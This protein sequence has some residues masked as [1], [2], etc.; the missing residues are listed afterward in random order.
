M[1]NQTYASRKPNPMLTSTNQMKLGVFALNI[2][3]GCT[4]TRAPERLKADDW[5]GNLK[6]AKA[7]DRA[8]FEA[9]LPVGRWRGFGGDSNP[10]GVS[11]ETYTW[12]AGLASVTDQ[13]GILT[14][15]HV[16]TVH[17]L[18]AAK[19]ATT[20]DHISGGRFGLNIICGWNSAEMKMFD[21]TMREHDERYDHA[22]EWIE[23]ARRAWTH[24]GEFDLK[25]KYF[26]I[27][28]G[29]SEPKP[30]NR[31]FLMNAG[32]SPRGKRFC[33]Q[34]CDAAYLIVKYQD[35][36]DVARAQIQSYRDLARKEFGRDLQIWCYA[37]VIQ[38]DTL[39]E[40]ERDL[41][42]YV[43]QMGD[44]L[45][46]TNVTKEIGIESGMFKSTEDAERFRYHIKAGFAG[47]PLVG[48]PEMIVSQFQ[49]YSDWG[50]DGIC[51]TWL[52][53][54]SG[55]QDFVDGVL[56]LMEDAGLRG[57]YPQARVRIA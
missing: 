26:N 39:A 14:T 13:I 2:E 15:S 43:N 34:H 25:G 31:P 49:K 23:V 57:T 22:D 8:G 42:Y 18:F 47:V 46:C 6:V 53:Y 27:E 30:L 29:F 45:A 44:E 56:P 40:A 12:A 19:Q 17:P 9:L 1:A 28:R 51:L 3:G 7:A 16:S 38:R 4:F 48:T 32:G 20:I 37:Y 5:L 41:D 52:D 36:E 21:G 55:I 35:G 33:A 24:Q 50:I 10:M 11:Y 54:H